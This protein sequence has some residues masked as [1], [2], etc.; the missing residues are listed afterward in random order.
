[1]SEAPAVDPVADPNPAPAPVIDPAV[2][3]A[4]TD[5]NPNDPPANYFSSQPDTWRT[6]LLSNAG[7]EGEEAEKR[8][9]QLERVMDI[10]TLT[11]NYFE[12]QDKI[13]K[14]ELSNGLPE[15]PTD[16]QVAEWREANGVP[17]AP[18]KY[19]LALDEGLVLGEEDTRIMEG[20]TKVAHKNNIPASAMSELTNAMLAGREAEAEAMEAQDGVDTQTTVRQL[21]DAWKGDY[22]TNTN[23]VQGL[24]SQLP[25][26]IRDDFLGARLADGKALFN[27]PEAMVFFADLARKVNPAGTVVPNSANPS[28]A[29]SDEIGKLE[30]RMTDPSWFKDKEAQNRLQELYRA[31]DAMKK[32]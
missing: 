5:P 31:R 32:Q 6:D 2:D 30:G 10:K 27:S 25:E 15:N 13:R 16:E 28:Q 20:V 23:M 12:A 14:G 3:P 29:V 19:E 18:D 7:F 24:I 17:E 11:K 9:G 26:S 8:A 22:Q 21:K 1:M 4:P